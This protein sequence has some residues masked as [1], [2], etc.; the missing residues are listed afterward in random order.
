MSR[1]AG[2]RKAHISVIAAWL[3]LT[4][5]IE[6]AGA[7]AVPI[8]LEVTP[9]SGSTADTFVA[10]VRVE[11]PGKRG[12]D[13][14]RPP[15]VDGFTIADKKVDRVTVRHYEPSTGLTHKT[16]EVHRYILQPVRSGTLQIGEAVI[17]H[18][19]REYRSTA[20][21]V[22]VHAA[23]DRGGDN[24]LTIAGV[25][26]P[27]F[28]A[29]PERRPTG[30]QRPQM[31]LH[32]VIDRESAYVGQQVTVTW[33]LYTRGEVLRFTPRLPRLDDFWS[34]ILYEPSGFLRYGEATVAGIPYQVVVL[35]KRALFATRPGRLTIGSFSVRIENLYSPLGSAVELVS[36]PLAIAVRPLPPGA[37]PGF[38]ASYV[39]EF[40][41][42][43]EVDRETS[44][45]GEPLT[46]TLTVRGRGAIRRTN[47]PAVEVPGFEVRMPRDFEESVDP[48]TGTVSGIR[49][50][51]Y[52]MS[53]QRAGTRVIPAIV[54]PSFNPDTARYE[55]NSSS[56]IDIVVT[57][58]S[59]AGRVPRA[60]SDLGERRLE[61]RPIRTELGPSARAARPIYR[62]P[63][64][65]ALALTPLVA[66]IF[67][68]LVRLASSRR[69]RP[70][71]VARQVEQIVKRGFRLADA[72][73]QAGRANAFFAQLCEILFLSLQEEGAGGGGTTD[74]VLQA[75]T[76]A[77][78]ASLL[79]ER[80]VPASVIARV[81]DAFEQCDRGRF[82]PTEIEI[83]E[84]ERTLELV[85]TLVD[86]IIQHRI[87]TTAG[88][89]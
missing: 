80:E 57:G 69:K 50:Y 9:E 55:Q 12:P 42:T 84:M 40:A 25:R 37:P 70:A 36:E 66:F 71:A 82:S 77:E 35:S 63:W 23:D 65:W 72:H 15:E 68:E 27:G 24:G 78:L 29:P 67:A 41:V 74:A 60:D 87:I 38:D 11:V 64:F 73:L 7:E 2:R 58:D 6:L 59:G 44:E 33:L 61:L 76:R 3:A 1:V 17:R 49:R 47:P 45:I 20:A 22:T 54:I 28:R 10:T 89:R 13:D 34:E 53:P 79:G 14:Y 46:L 4:G 5:S 83:E 16:F 19:G 56:P 26:V 48:S 8:A 32:A 51:R 39:G 88:A 86:D 85:R 31:F 62:A 21:V 30:P 52:W 81:L 18:Q 75:L 43:S